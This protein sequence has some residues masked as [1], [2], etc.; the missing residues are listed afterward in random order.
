MKIK[1][2]LYFFGFVCLFWGLFFVKN[3]NASIYQISP[4]DSFSTSE[5]T[6]HYNVEYYSNLSS[7]NLAGRFN[8]FLINDYKEKDVAGAKEVSFSLLNYS[9]AAGAITVFDK[10]GGIV[11]FR[12]FAGYEGVPSSILDGDLPYH[13]VRDAYLRL[14]NTIAYKSIF[15]DGLPLYNQTDTTLYVPYDGFIRVSYVSDEALFYNIYEYAVDLVFKALGDLVPDGASHT[16]PVSQRQFEA[17]YYSF[18]NSSILTGLKNG[19]YKSAGFD[20]EDLF[21]ESVHNLIVALTKAMLEGDKRT[22]VVKL[23]NS[24]YEKANVY[25]TVA[26]YGITFAKGYA[27]WQNYRT[28]LKD[29]KQNTVYIDYGNDKGKRGYHG[30]YSGAESETKEL[31]YFVTG[32]KTDW[33]APHFLDITR[34]DWYTPYINKLRLTNGVIQGFPDGTFRPHQKVTRAEFIKMAVVGYEYAHRITLSSTNNYV[35]SDWYIPYLNKGK[36]IKNESTGKSPVYW[37]VGYSPDFNAPI[38]RLEAARVLFNTTILDIND[39]NANY[40]LF[41][42]TFPLA[43]EEMKILKALYEM[44][45]F[46]GFQDGSFGINESL[47]RAQAA[48]IICEIYIELGNG[49]ECSPRPPV[50]F[51]EPNANERYWG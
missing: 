17:L 5:S 47:T 34:F 44:E 48:K 20:G 23:A 9:V 41:T 24:I 36:T 43:Q 4:L 16:Y 11:E 39:F 19:V 2:G 31:E 29:R 3:V 49:G 21:K 45:V 50:L 37:Q 13:F 27:K 40:G 12:P 51:Y 18:R 28:F 33:F 26:D 35:G 42:D 38:S 10:E 32:I 7:R 8:G 14:E 22:R 46:Q 1:Y 15:V 30:G 6:T 25:L